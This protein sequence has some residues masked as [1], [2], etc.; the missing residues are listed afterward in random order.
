MRA[1]ATALA[2]LALAVVSAEDGQ[3]PADC[4]CGA[5]AE[6][7]AAD[8]GDAVLL[9]AVDAHN[10]SSRC[11]WPDCE[12]SSTVLDGAVYL[13]ALVYCFVWPGVSLISMNIF[14]NIHWRKRLELHR[15]QG[16]TVD[17]RCFARSSENVRQVVVDE[18]RLVTVHHIRIAFCVPMP[19]PTATA[20]FFQVTKE[21]QVVEHN[22]YIR[23]GDI[24]KM[25]HIMPVTG[26][27]CSAME[28]QMLQNSDNKS[29]FVQ[30]LFGMAFV[31]MPLYY[32]LR[33]IMGRP[34]LGL[35]CLPIFVGVPVHSNYRCAKDLEKRL[36]DGDVAEVNEQTAADLL[37]VPLIPVVMAD[38]VV[39]PSTTSNNNPLS[40]AAEPLD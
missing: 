29:V 33:M 20:A 24:V 11:E 4:C 30:V 7:Q 40:S 12:G 1:L 25:N 36:N 13:C 26:N 31:A 23:E 28:S 38:G 19:N 2:L 18:T 22:R 15:T 8:C 32:V 10:C 3:Q 35:F 37:T 14:G 9:C 5:S 21:I 16:Q 34:L 6:T 27:P 39:A 17:G